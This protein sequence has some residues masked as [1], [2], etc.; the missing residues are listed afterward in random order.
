P[1]YGVKFGSNFQPFVRSRDVSH[2][3]DEDMT[4]E[5]EMV[6]AYRDTWELGLHSYLTYLRDRLLL[7]RELLANSGSVFV[8]ISDQNLH[9]VR[10]LLDEIFGDQN[11]VSVISY[12]TTGGFESSTLSRAGDYLLWY[13]R[14]KEQIKYR[15]LFQRKK[16]PFEDRRSKYDQ[17]EL[18]DGTRRALT[19]D[20]KRGDEE[21]P[22]GSRI[23][24]VDNIVS[25][26]A[27]EN[28]VREYYYADQRFPCGENNHFKASVPQGMDRLAAA[29]RLFVTEKGKLG[30][31]RFFDDFPYIGVTNIWDDI[32]GAVQSRSDRKIY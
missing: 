23:F 12:T 22:E 9:H 4:R 8:Q 5:P 20:E 17:L 10:E 15:S 13:C 7:A 24:R 14:N 19:L 31:V 28:T 11:F 18:P 32:G 3:D 25:Q 16:S 29:K 6:Q 21:I 2:N 26:G 27:S 30:Y 1:P